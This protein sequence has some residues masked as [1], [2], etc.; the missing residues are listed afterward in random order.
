MTGRDAILFN[1]R[2]S[3]NLLQMFTADLSREELHHRVVP[4]ANCA[5]WLLGH[6]VLSERRGLA[7]LGVDEG[8][9]PPLPSI[10]FAETFARDETGPH[11]DDYGE[12]T[13]LPAL[14]DAHRK[15]VIAA[16]EAA[17]DDAFTKPLPQKS[18]VAETTG[19]LLLFFAVHVATH[20]GQIS[21]IRRSLGKPPLI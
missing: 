10:E 9:M 3:G 14:F 7:L 19:E 15:E 17:D 21:T 4:D 11:R 12:A 1:L 8:K 16:V 5:A 20:L 6:M 13:E 2:S 18:P